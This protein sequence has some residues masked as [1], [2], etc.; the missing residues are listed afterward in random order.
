MTSCGQAPV[1]W[2]SCQSYSV[3]N[4][5]SLNILY[6]EDFLRPQE[7]TTY[8]FLIFNSIK[9]KTSEVG[10][11]FPFKFIEIILYFKCVGGIVGLHVVQGTFFFL[12]INNKNM[13]KKHMAR[14]TVKE[15]VVYFIVNCFHVLILAQKKK[16]YN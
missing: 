6:L 11:C 3:S 2:S 16:Q 5:T 4:H 12:Q 10:I 15:K 13:K 8:Y 7:S 1:R 9:Q 14:N